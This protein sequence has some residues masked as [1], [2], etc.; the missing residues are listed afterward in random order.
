[1]S[2]VWGQTTSTRGSVIVPSTEHAAVRLAAE[3]T[4]RAVVVPVD[5]GGR[6]DPEDVA[7]AI[8]REHRAG[9][10]VSLACCQLANHEVGTIQPVHE[11][12]AACRARGVALLVDAA[13][14]AGRI[15]FDFE[16]GD[17]TFAAVSGHKLGGPPGSGVLLVK[18]GVR[19]EP[20]LVGGLQ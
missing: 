5:G 8:D 11:I 12:A 18:G 17:A 14:G 16:A 10:D 13:Q 9:R 20:L 7:V 4:G 1:M 2:A 15:P 6:V 3:R 19:I